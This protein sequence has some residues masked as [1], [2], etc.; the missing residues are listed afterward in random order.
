MKLILT[1][2]DD[3]DIQSVAFVE[4]EAA[5]NLELVSA[6]GERQAVVDAKDV[7]RGLDEDEADPEKLAAHQA[8]IIKGFRV[9][10]TSRLAR[11]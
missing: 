7:G 6:K 11:R 8:R 9:E 3:G 5:E 4:R 2:D 1:H 10:S